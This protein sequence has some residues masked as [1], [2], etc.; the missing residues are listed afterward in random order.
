MIGD[1]F[2][3]VLQLSQLFLFRY[4]TL[5][6]RENDIPSYKVSGRVLLKERKIKLGREKI[7]SQNASKL[8]GN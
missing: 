7:N 2:T 4:T 3:K 6:I 1:Y 8:I 5:G